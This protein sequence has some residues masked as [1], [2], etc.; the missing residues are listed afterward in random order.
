MPNGAHAVVVVPQ[1]ATE[2]GAIAAARAINELQ[3][4]CHAKRLS[5]ATVN[6]NPLPTHLA[7]WRVHTSGCGCGVPRSR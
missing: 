4:E 3:G 2:A 1:D 6:G 7:A 5:G